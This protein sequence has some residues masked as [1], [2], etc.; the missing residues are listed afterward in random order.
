MKYLVLLFSLI[1]FLGCASRRTPLMPQPKDFVYIPSGKLSYDTVNYDVASFYMTETTVTNKQYR[2]YLDAVGKKLPT[3]AETLIKNELWISNY[4]DYFN[5]P[6]FDYFP[7]VGLTKTEMIDYANWLSDKVSKEYP[8]WN[9]EFRLP[10]KYEW[11]YAAC[12]GRG[13]SNFPWGG[14]S[15]TN[16]KGCY[17]LWAF[18]KNQQTCLF[19]D[20]SVNHEFYDRSDLPDS[21]IQIMYNRILTCTKNLTK[22]KRKNI[23]CSLPLIG[24]PVYA[25]AYFPNDYGL[26]NMS[27][28]VAQMTYYGEVLGGSYR[29]SSAYCGIKQVKKYPFDATQPQSDI[30]FRLVCSYQSPVVKKE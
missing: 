30:G 25:D 20:N 9:F 29:I 22:T 24:F 5:N 16:S 2:I 13:N 23:G 28:N 27:G 26:Y 3:V 18:T 14:Q 1:L 21:L 7:I 19:G 17:L 11:Q 6:I 15:D 10:T 12:G 4:L 8:P